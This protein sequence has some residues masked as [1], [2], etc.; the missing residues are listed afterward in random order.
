MAIGSSEYYINYNCLKKVFQ[1]WILQMQLFNL[2]WYEYHKLE[3][4]KNIKKAKNIF[5]KNIFSIF[6]G[7]LEPQNISQII[8]NF[9]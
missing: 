9:I 6:R 3:D 4:I 5:F 2:L 1:S 8:S 7:S